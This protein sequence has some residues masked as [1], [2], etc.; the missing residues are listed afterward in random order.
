MLTASASL[1]CL[2][3]TAKIFFFILKYVPS[4]PEKVRKF[5]NRNVDMGRYKLQSTIIV[6]AVCSETLGTYK[7]P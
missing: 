4:H 3:R 2:S 1:F 6:F 5:P 7:T